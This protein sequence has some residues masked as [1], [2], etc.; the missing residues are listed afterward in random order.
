MKFNKL[1]R[2]IAAGF[3]LWAA[4][5]Y[6]VASIPSG[7]QGPNP[8]YHQGFA[9]S[10]SESAYPESRKG[11]IGA[12]TPELGVSGFTLH[13]ASGFSRNGVISATTTWT[14]GA[15]RKS[16][17]YVLDYDGG[18][19]GDFTD[20][21][22]GLDNNGEITV[23][24]WVN[25]DAVTG[26]T[27]HI[28]SNIDTSLSFA[29]YSLEINR[30]AGRLSVLWDAAV[31]V[32]GN[33]ALSAGTWYHVAFI[34]AGTTSD[35]TG[36]IYVD[37]VLD[38]SATSAT[39]PNAI[40]ET[41]AIGR[42]GSSAS[43]SFT[44]NGQVGSVLMYD[45]ALNAGEIKFHYQTS[46]APFILRPRHFVRAPAAA[47]PSTTPFRTLMGT[48]TKIIEKFDWRDHLKDTGGVI[49]APSGVEWEKFERR[50]YP[51]GDTYCY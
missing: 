27:D 13:D 2:F 14:V 41:T 18:A 49:D 23:V 28:I 1:T 32:T 33:V 47:P 10:A 31:I 20:L 21:G 42:A 11:L 43:S 8:S 17:G 50:A 51:C 38:N 44:F 48:G 25:P 37:G 24:L 9:R 19:S 4:L 7:F 40:N 12:W 45:R 35:W 22:T 29:D 30:T 34:R 46:L 39:N 36:L 15:N 3:F 16:P 6:S 5:A 26:D